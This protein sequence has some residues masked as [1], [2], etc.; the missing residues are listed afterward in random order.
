MDDCGGRTNTH[1]MA[2]MTFEMHVQIILL[3]LS[4]CGHVKR[5]TSDGKKDEPGKNGQSK[6]MN[7]PQEK[8]MLC[9]FCVGRMC[10]YLLFL[11]LNHIL[12][13]VKDKIIQYPFVHHR[14]VIHLY[15]R[16]RR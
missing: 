9:L 11:T 4:Q 8:I 14:R 5:K 16:S 13:A 1:N 10:E 7:L 15:S 6:D 3:N 12:H 2:G